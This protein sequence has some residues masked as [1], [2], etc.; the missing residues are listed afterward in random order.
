MKV[1][2]LFLLLLLSSCGNSPLLN[3]NSESSNKGGSLVSDSDTLKF[4]NSDYSF[5]ISWEEGPQLGGSRFRMKT[6][7]N[8][9]GSISGPYQDLSKSLHIL[10]W[11]PSMGHGS[12]PVTITKVGDGEYEV[13]DVQFIMGGTW[14][15]KFQLKD[16]AQI[17]DETI[18]SLPL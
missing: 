6:W 9:L 11:M 5:I 4:V 15:I 17:F 2:S 10:L 7:K 13:T 18:I 8:D 12:S 16:G 3:H 14:Q 1:L